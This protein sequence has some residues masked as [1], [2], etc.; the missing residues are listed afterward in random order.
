[1]SAATIDSAIGP[2]YITETR[3][4]LGA[5]HGKIKHCIRQLNE[6]QIWQRP[7]ESMNSIGNVLLHLSVNHCRALYRHCSY[8]ATS[9]RFPFATTRCPSCC[10]RIL[11]W[12]MPPGYLGFTSPPDFS[13]RQ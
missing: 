1:M 4:R 3:R 11:I 9:K 12:A 7:G 6:D 2:A 10:K 5:C 13:V 8:S